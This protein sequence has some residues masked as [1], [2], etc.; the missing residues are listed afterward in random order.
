MSERHKARAWSESD[1]R[2]VLQVL[3]EIPK[4]RIRTDGVEAIC[5]ALD[6]DVT[7]DLV[8][9]RLKALG[10]GAPGPW[11]KGENLGPGPDE[12]ILDCDLSD[13]EFDARDTLPMPAPVPTVAQMAEEEAAAIANGGWTIECKFEPSKEI[14]DRIHVYRQPEPAAEAMPTGIERVAIIPDTHV[15]AHDVAAWN[16]A[17]KAIKAFK[18][19]TIVFLGDFGDLNSVSSHGKRPDKIEHLKSDVAAV[20]A[21]LDR[22]GELGAARVIFCEGNHEF[23]AARF[24]QD[25]APEL[26][27]MFT[28][29]ELFKLDERGWEYVPYRSFAKLGKL[30]LTHDCGHA[31]TTSAVRSRESFGSNVVVGHSHFAGIAYRGDAHGDTH[32]GVSS[33]WLGDAKSVSYMHKVSVARN[34]QHAFSV[35]YIDRQRGDA[36][37]HLIPLINGRCVVEGRVIQ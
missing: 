8:K 5:V 12:V 4:G 26:Y 32:V 9:A 17:L 14:A 23:R 2:T 19:D 21:E 25:R 24:I 31:G 16:L 33:G 6:D 36:H 13:L 20:N 35:A 22:V 27:G 3:G 30:H 34:W 1:V 11:C 28:I 15:P 29:R 18:A 10:L 37:V 7:Y